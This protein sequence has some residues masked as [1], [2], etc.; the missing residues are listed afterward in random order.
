MTRRR[1]PYLQKV[2][3]DHLWSLEFSRNETQTSTGFRW[4]GLRFVDFVG[5]LLEGVD[6]LQRRLLDCMV[7]STQEIDLLNILALNNNVLQVQ[8]CNIAFVVLSRRE[9]LES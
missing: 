4:V 8:F 3:I 7:K 6:W 9:M 1:I 5:R 2:T